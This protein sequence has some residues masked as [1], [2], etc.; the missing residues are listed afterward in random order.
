M[1]LTANQQIA[2]ACEAAHSPG[3][4]AQ[5][6]QFYN[7]ILSDLC[8]QYDF[9]DARGIFLFNFNP[10]L[11]STLPGG[12]FGSGPYPLPLDYLRASGSSGSSGAP[13]FAIWYLNGV[14]YPLICCDL[15]EF[16]M[17]IQQAGLQ[18]YPWLVA[19]NMGDVTTDRFALI[20]TG[21]ITAGNAQV[22]NLQSA[23]NL[24]PGQGCAGEGIVPGTTV[25]SVN[26]VAKSCVLSSAPTATIT[27]A[28]NTVGAS[29]MFGVAPSAFF[30]NPPSSNFQVQIRYQRQ[31]PD[32]FN[33]N[34]IPWFRHQ[35]YL[36]EELKARLY[37]L[38][39][40][41][42]EAA[43]HAYADT[44]LDGYLKL[45]DDDTNRAKRIQLDRRRF[46]PLATKLKYTKQVPW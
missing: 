30:Y 31:M 2:L 41:T 3:K 37:G 25:V 1:P 17:Q 26:S 24:A 18:S 46:R 9:A 8:E 13:R 20:T 16:D 45:K 33:F 10:G 42:R 19:T 7:E 36:Q 29:L 27:A 38:N 28:A 14:P 6:Q 40:D 43:T 44:L 23:L 15:A 11:V 35:G 22:T 34:K 39:D 21:D 5:A 32:L 4:T 12:Q